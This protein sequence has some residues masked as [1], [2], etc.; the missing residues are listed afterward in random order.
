MWKKGRFIKKKQTKKNKRWTAQD[1]SYLQWCRVRWTIGTASGNQHKKRKKK[2]KTRRLKIEIL[3]ADKLLLRNERIPEQEPTEAIWYIKIVIFLYSVSVLFPFVE[4][5]SR[6]QIFV[7]LFFF[8]L[9]VFFSLS[10]CESFLPCSS[11][12]LLDKKT[13]VWTYCNNKCCFLDV[14]CI[15][16]EGLNLSATNFTSVC[17]CDEKKKRLKKKKI[18]YGMAEGRCQTD[19]LVLVIHNFSIKLDCRHVFCFCIWKKKKKKKGWHVP[20]CLAILFSNTVSWGAF[21]PSYNIHP[22]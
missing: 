20:W 19:Q 5:Y 6:A 22:L 21:S 13:C 10:G 7:F 1:R 18:K 12:I 2:R 16:G 8:F 17:V 15:V 9:P 11:L 4:G 14:N 3:S